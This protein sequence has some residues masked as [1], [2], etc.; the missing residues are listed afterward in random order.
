M[1]ARFLAGFLLV[2]IAISAIG[3]ASG[4]TAQSGAA[5][6][7]KATPTLP[8]PTASG[9]GPATPNVGAKTEAAN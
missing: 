3:C 1:Q 4:D 6:D 8:P 5:P 9:G 2:G 7:V